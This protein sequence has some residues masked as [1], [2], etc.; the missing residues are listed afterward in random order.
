[1][2]RQRPSLRVPAPEQGAR[3]DRREAP[4]RSRPADPTIVDH[5]VDFTVTDSHTIN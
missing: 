4:K 5:S 3:P 2:Q 1:M